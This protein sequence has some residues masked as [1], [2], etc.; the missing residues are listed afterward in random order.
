MGRRRRIARCNTD[1]RH[2]GFEHGFWLEQDFRTI[3]DAVGVI[4]QI[5]RTASIFVLLLR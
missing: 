5:E 4:P 2:D 1:G 3:G